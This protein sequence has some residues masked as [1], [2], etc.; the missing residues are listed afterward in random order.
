[1]RGSEG[2]AV[3]GYPIVVRFVPSVLCNEQKT[4]AQSAWPTG[5]GSRYDAPCWSSEYMNVNGARLWI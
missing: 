4:S 1:V 3:G 5:G 2:R